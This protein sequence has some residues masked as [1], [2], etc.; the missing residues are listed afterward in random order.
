MS[1]QLR[2]LGVALVLLLCS[3]YSGAAQIDLRGYVRELLPAQKVT[4]AYLTVN[5]NLDHAVSLRNISA[6][7][8]AMAHLHQT[9]K[10][11]EGRMMMSAKDSLIIESGQSLVMVPGGLHIML[12][13]V[14]RPMVAGEQLKMSLQFEANGQLLPEQSVILDVRS[15]RE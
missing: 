2:K 7:N 12:M 14:T 3:Q 13:G 11:A 15:I 8:V 6:E 9:Q 4:A 5:N 1:D 10:G